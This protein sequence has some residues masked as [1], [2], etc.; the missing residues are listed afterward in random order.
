M[1]LFLG[2]RDPVFGSHVA[3]ALLASVRALTAID[4]WRSLREACRPRNCNSAYPHNSRFANPKNDAADVAAA[5]RRLG[6]QS[7]KAFE[8]GQGAF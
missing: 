1:P 2:T 7:S 8:S 3:L 5:L 6:F 4:G